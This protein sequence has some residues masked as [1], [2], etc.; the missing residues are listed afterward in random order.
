M[1]LIV[2]R[3]KAGETQPRSLFSTE[4][5]RLMI[6]QSLHWSNGDQKQRIRIGMGK[7][8]KALFF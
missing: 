5:S 6:P 2:V 7:G 4:L 1:F 8:E 3:L